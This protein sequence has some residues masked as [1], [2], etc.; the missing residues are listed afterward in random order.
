MLKDL[1]DNY[2]IHKTDDYLSFTNPLQTNRHIGDL[3][4]RLAG[5][6]VFFAMLKST[7]KPPQK[8][9]RAETIKTNQQIKNRSTYYIPAL[10][11]ISQYEYQAA[12]RNILIHFFDTCASVP[13]FH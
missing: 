1:V 4:S 11:N 3:H 10:N 2:L 7:I 5:S 13:A 9:S 6:K 12:G 8:A